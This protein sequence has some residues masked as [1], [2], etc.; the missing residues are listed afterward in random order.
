M[1]TQTFHGPKRPL[2]RARVN[3][4]KHFQI[5]VYNFREKER[6]KKK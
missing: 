1:H 2:L 3:G 5:T 6:G 4:K